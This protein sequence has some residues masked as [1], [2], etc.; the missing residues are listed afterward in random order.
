MFGS[1]RS[2]QNKNKDEY[3]HEKQQIYNRTWKCKIL[4]T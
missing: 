2:K 3:I 1:K 4:L